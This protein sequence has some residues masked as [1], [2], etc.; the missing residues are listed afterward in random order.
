MQRASIEAATALMSSGNSRNTN[1]TLPVSIYFDFSIGKTFCSNAA[2]CGQVI[3]AYSVMLTAAFA[4]PTAISGSSIGFATNSAVEPCALA[5]PI[6]GSGAKAARAASP[7]SDKA[8]A[9]ARRIVTINGLL[10]KLRF[11]AASGTS[12]SLAG[13]DHSG[14]GGRYRRMAGRTN[15]APLQIAAFQP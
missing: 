3:D 7:A 5:L 8:A 10:R 1:R 4:D 15:R 12:R 13:N 9:K 14:N 2:Q 6:R 11:A